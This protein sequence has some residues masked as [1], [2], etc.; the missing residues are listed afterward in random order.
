MKLIVGLGNPGE[1]Y[2]NTKHNVGFLVLDNIA[3]KLGITFKEEKKFL[4][5]IAKNKEVV[6]LKPMTYMNNSGQSVSLVS[7]F[8]KIASSDIIVVQD[9]VDLEV[10]KVKYQAGIS[11]AGHRG[12]ESIISQIKSNEFN[13][14]R[15]GI[16]RPE[17][18][19]FDVEDWVL[20]KLDD[21]NVKGL[22]KIS[23]QIIL[24]YL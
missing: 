21:N 20:S 9:E 3:S 24:K 6:L 15:I 8:F 12:V 11:S 10:G 19:K 5:Q 7:S 13:R 1:K 17:V 16:G 2:E 18:N 4:G 14:V 23:D 22:Q